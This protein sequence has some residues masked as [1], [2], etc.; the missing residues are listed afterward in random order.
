[1]YE[2]MWF[3]GGVVFTVVAVGLFCWLTPDD[4]PERLSILD[5]IDQIER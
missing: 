1:M 5:R 2:A 4:E 3:L